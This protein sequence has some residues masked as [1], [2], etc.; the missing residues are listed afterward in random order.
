MNPIQSAIETIFQVTV[1]HKC[2]RNSFT[3]NDTNDMLYEILAGAAPVVNVPMSTVT[4]AIAGCTLVFSVEIL[5]YPSNSWT[6]V[7]QANSTAKYSFIVSDP[8]LNTGSSNSFDVQTA[9]F[10]SWANTSQF[11]RLRVQDPNST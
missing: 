3:I 9:D 10:A 5:D 8:S 2:S 6:V 11:M 7:R 4:G 1:F